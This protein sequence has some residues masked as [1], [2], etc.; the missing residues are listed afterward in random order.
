MH[1]AFN[2]SDI[3]YPVEYKHVAMFTQTQEEEF[4]TLL[5]AFVELVDKKHKDFPVNNRVG[6]LRAKIEL[7]RITSVQ[8]I[9][10]SM[11]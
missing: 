5:G 11:P 1:N 4:K 6:F 8:K 2:D 9:H 7:N 3:N 10:L